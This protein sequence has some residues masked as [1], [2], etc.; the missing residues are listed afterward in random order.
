MTKVCMFALKYFCPELTPERYAPSSQLG[1]NWFQNKL[2]KK[3]KTPEEKKAKKAAKK[4]AK[5]AKKGQVKKLTKFVLSLT[6]DGKGLEAVHP[7]AFKKQ[8]MAERAARTKIQFTQV[9]RYSN[10]PGSCCLSLLF[11]LSVRLSEPTLLTLLSRYR[12][13]WLC[14][15][16]H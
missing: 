1:L 2:T 11:L 7:E 12:Y 10:S 5:K 6:E 4:K 16:Y 9:R 8:D 3:K 13:I 15:G 14:M